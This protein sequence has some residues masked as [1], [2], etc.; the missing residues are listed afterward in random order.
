LVAP[1]PARLAL[2]SAL[3]IG[4]LEGSSAVS[5]IAAA[6]LCVVLVPLA[7]RMDGRGHHRRGPMRDLRGAWLTLTS[8]VVVVAE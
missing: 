7:A 1:A 2:T 3:M 6:G 5:V 4:V 8:L